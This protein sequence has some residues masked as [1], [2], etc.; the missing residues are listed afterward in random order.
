MAP[1]AGGTVCKIL[2]TEEVKAEQRALLSGAPRSVGIRIPTAVRQERM[3]SDSLFWQISGNSVASFSDSLD[4]EAPHRGET[5]ANRILT[6]LL[7]TSHPIQA[8]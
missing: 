6:F 4:Q 7:P 8:R 2:V 1:G 3:P 5:C